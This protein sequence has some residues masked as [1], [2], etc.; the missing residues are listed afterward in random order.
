M[1]DHLLALSTLIYLLG[2]G[3]IVLFVCGYGL[4]LVIY[5]LTRRQ[6]PT[7]PHIDDDALLSVTVQLPVYNEAHVVDR[8][9][10][11]C[12]A[13]DYPAHKL[14]IQIIDDSNDHT[15]AMIRRR[16]D[17]LHRRGFI[18][19]SHIRRS[20][21]EGYKAGALAAAMREVFTDCVVV[22]DADFVPGPDFLR[23]TM[24]HFNADPRLGLVQT[25]WSHINRGTNLLTRAQALA[26]DA[27]FA[28][29]QVARSRGKLPMAMN[30]TGGIWRVAA[31]Q[32]AGG[33]SDATLTEDLDLSYR[34][35]LRGW[36]FL[37]RVDVAVPGELPP[38]VQAYKTQQARWATG[39]TQC[40]L[41]HSPALL[42]HRHI[43]LLGKLMGLLHL[44]QYVVQPVIL[45]L[46][47]LTPPLLA[48]G[49]FQTMPDLTLVAV[50][51]VIPPAMIALGQMAL[52]DD[53]RAHLLAF[54]VQFLTAV[55][56]VIS[57]S[58]AVLNAFGLG[59]DLEF[60][61]TPKYRLTAD[62]A[63]RPRWRRSRYQSP[64]DST[65]LL[66]MVM[67]IYALFGLVIAWQTLPAFMP[68]MLTYALAFALFGG[69]NLAQRWAFKRS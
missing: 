50:I 4:L 18:N 54:P 29:E 30:G 11:A 62:H 9:I 48:G 24:A 13:L 44:A 17:A 45:V 64:V 53:W 32:D 43:G 39:S 5:L 56:I 7:L 47:L 21:R 26:I 28:V 67:A 37:Y 8:L 46:F 52:Y 69:W 2:T 61:R 6:A 20:S 65:T 12:V 35:F 23:Q 68:Y 60:K 58:R 19:I 41:R 3:F 22:F 51:G 36:R 27:H 38:L 57:N 55:A 59:S 31:I 25:R 33:W 14:F 15:T 40:L 16:V 63:Q 66:E 10:A 42:A 34:A 1:I 49:R